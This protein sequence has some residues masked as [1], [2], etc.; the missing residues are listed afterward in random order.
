MPHNVYGERQ[1]VGDKYR[2][3]IGIFMNQ[4]MRGEPLTVFGDGTQTRAFTHV[5]DVAPVIARSVERS[6]AWGKV[7]NVGAD[8]P[9]TVKRLAETVSKC[10]EA[11]PKI[12]FLPSR[13][14]VTHAFSS[15]E[16]VRSLFGDLVK[17][18][19]LEEGIQRMATWARA[20]GSRKSQTFNQI[21]IEKNLPTSWVE[22][23]GAG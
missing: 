1:N 23:N 3:V 15:H 9:Y 14:E 21:E 16:K 7:F 22:S 5:D 8:E 2:N 4:I 13:Q 19:S 10:M 20:H 18:M 6:A 17:D 12:R 11:E